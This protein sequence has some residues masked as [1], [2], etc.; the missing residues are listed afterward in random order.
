MQ[1]ES[2][3]L[4]LTHDEALVLFDFLSRFGETDELKIE[5]RGEQQA[6]WNL[7]CLVEKQL[8]GALDSNYRELVRQ[9]RA[10]LR[11]PS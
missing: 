11:D 5:G 6:L 4:V 1:P 7:Q 8:A 9:A 3:N 10:R 2:I